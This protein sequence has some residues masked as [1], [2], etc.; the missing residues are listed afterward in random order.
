MVFI[1]KIIYLKYVI[2]LD[3]DKSIRTHWLNLIVNGNIIIY[4]DSFGVEHIPKEIRNFIGNKN[5]KTN[6]YRR[7]AYNSIMCGYVSTGF[8]GFVWNSKSL[9][10]YTDLISPNDYEQNGKIILKC[11]Q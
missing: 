1:Q 4:F 3:E 5:I 7:Q 2:N 10:E 6:I 8:I 11:F 9:V